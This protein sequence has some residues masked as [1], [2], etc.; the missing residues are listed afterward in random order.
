MCSLTLLTQLPLT[1][2]HKNETAKCIKSPLLRRVTLKCRNIASAT[3]A[4]LLAKFVVVFCAETNAIMWS[5]VF[6]LALVLVVANARSCPEIASVPNFNPAAYLGSWYE[7]ANSAAMRETFERGC[8]CTVATY[9]LNAD[10][11]IKVNNTCKKDGSYESAIGV[12]IT[13]NAT[14]PSKLEVRFSDLSPYAPYWVIIND[15]YM[16]A[17]VWS[18]V[19]FDEF[20]IGAA[21]WILSRN[22]TMDPNVYD[23]L[24]AKAGSLTGFDTA[25]ELKLTD[26]SCH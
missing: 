19:E 10:S 9:T 21:M 11:T 12:A 25:G 8:A 23:A 26:Q 22:S 17:A 14:E 20:E 16:N 6:V 24:V 18:C 13:P 2:P 5:T 3:K 15:N 1:I 4:P 7:I